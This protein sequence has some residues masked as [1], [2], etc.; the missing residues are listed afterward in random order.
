MQWLL[1]CNWPSCQRKIPYRQRRWK[2]SAAG[3]WR[4]P[5][6]GH[7][8]GGFGLARIWRQEGER[9]VPLNIAHAAAFT[10]GKIIC[11]SGRSRFQKLAPMV[12]A[13]HSAQEGTV[14]AALRRNNEAIA[15]AVRSS[16]EATNRRAPGIGWS[17]KRTASW[18]KIRDRLRE[19][20]C[21]FQPSNSHH[22]PWI[23]PSRSFPMPIGI[24][25]ARQWIGSKFSIGFQDPDNWCSPREPDRARAVA[26]PRRCLS[27]S[28]KTTMR[29]I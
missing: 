7:R 20:A 29:Q 16:V 19:G 4:M 6:W 14:E 5:S 8:G 1:G 15:S 27:D 22:S 17:F 23:S 2:L 25:V 3:A 21:L 10:A 11:R 12:G 9:Q 28:R 24:A 13:R 18:P 26:V